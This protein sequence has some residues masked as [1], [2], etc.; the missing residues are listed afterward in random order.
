[1]VHSQPNERFRKMVNLRVETQRV[2]H[3]SKWGKVIEKELTVDPW[4]KTR[5]LL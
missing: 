5:G 1:M 3:I 4:R 2:L